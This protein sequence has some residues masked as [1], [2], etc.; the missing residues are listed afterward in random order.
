MGKLRKNVHV[1]QRNSRI[2][3][4]LVAIC[5]VILISNYFNISYD[6]DIRCTRAKEGKGGHARC[7]YLK[8]VSGIC[9]A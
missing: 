6:K 3:S 1:N 8:T 5:V 2:A 4:L 7:S 9:I